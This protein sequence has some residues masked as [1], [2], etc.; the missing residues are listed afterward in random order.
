MY[1]NILLRKADCKD[2][3]RNINV[4]QE[5]IHTTLYLFIKNPQSAFAEHMFDVKKILLKLCYNTL[6]GYLSFPHWG[7]LYRQWM[8]T[9]HFPGLQNRSYNFELAYATGRL[10]TIYI[11]KMYWFIWIWLAAHS[12]VIYINSLNSLWQVM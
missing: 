4:Y 12:E 7:V 11:T 8:S 5:Y 3:K 1:R 9:E 10:C 2:Y 6:P